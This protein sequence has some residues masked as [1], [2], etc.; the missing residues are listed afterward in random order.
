[1][2]SRDILIV[3]AV[4]LAWLLDP[5]TGAA[6]GGQQSHT[7]VQILL[8]ATVLADKAFDRVSR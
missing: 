6:A 8:A 2:V 5:V 1:M 7:A 4:L 3:A